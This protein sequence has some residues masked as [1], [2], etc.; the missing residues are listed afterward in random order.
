MQEVQTE[1]IQLDPKL[2][3]PIQRALDRAPV[4]ALLPVLH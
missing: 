3:I 1:A 4:E 2:R